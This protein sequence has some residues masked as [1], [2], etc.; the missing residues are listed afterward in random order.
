MKRIFQMPGLFFFFQSIID[1]PLEPKISNFHLTGVN[2]NN[3]SIRVSM[4]AL[5]FM[6]KW[7][8]G[9]S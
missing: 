9:E 3:C 8:Q 5:E 1:L 4:T 2:E 7:H 6:F